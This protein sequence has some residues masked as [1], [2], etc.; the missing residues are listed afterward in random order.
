MPHT[1]EHAIDTERLRRIESTRQIDAVQVE[2]Q[3]LTRERLESR[4]VGRPL[5]PQRSRNRRGPKAQAGERHD[6]GE[7]G[8]TRDGEHRSRA[9]TRPEQEDTTQCKLDADHPT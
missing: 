1:T 8:G 5:H 4:T 7:P 9:T 3:Q 2:I 6:Q